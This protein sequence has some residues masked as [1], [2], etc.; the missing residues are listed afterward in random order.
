MET[1]LGGGGGGGAT[2]DG[3]EGVSDN[4]SSMPKR[5]VAIWVA[6]TIYPAV[7]A[8]E[9]DNLLED[10]SHGEQRNC[11]RLCWPKLVTEKRGLARPLF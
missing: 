3:G 6:N 1:L 4:G 11:E 2:G 5:I 7:A 9:E 8:Q 10:K